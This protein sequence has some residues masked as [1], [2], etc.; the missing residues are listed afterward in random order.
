MKTIFGAMNLGQQVLGAEADRM[1]IAFRDAG[2]SEVDTAYVY[3]DGASELL[4]GVC[5]DSLGSSGFKVSTKVNPRVTGR[6]DCSAVQTQLNTSLMRLGLNSVDV[7]YLHFPDR[8]TP[9]SSAL[10]GCARLYEEGKFRELGVSDFPLSLVE[11]MGAVCDG[12][13]CPRPS[14]FEG[15][16]NALS[17]KAELELLPELGRLGMRF[18]AYNPLA[19]GMLTGKYTNIENKPTEGRFA[20]R[21]ASYQGRYWRESFFEAVRLIAAACDEVCIPIAEAAYRWISNHSMLEASRDDGVIVGASKMS[22]LQQNMASL[23]K[24]PL[25]N[26][27]LDAF[28]CAWEITSEEAPEYYRFYSGGRAV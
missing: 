22:Q 15:V 23:G 19:G 14:V 17:R 8:D 7:L 27:L 16:Y 4:L 2:G 6:L 18:H 11:E 13:G 26:S 21:A 3:N 1:L 20:L 10:E 24:G 5:L 12:L 28:D 25:P 9:V